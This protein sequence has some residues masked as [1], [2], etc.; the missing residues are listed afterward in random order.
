[1]NLGQCIERNAG[2]PGSGRHS[3]SG[4]F[5]VKEAT[6]KRIADSKRAYFEQQIQNSMNNAHSWRSNN[7]D[8]AKKFEEQAS[9]YAQMKTLSD[10]ELYELAKKETSGEL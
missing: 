8:R 1:M 10:K 5:S 7:P 3:E 2:G 9:K 6:M 4:L